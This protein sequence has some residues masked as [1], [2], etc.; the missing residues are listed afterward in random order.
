MQAWF[1]TRPYMIQWERLHR[2]RRRTAP[3]MTPISSDA[4]TDADEAFDYLLVLYASIFQMRDWIAAS[5]PDLKTDVEDLFKDSA[6]L[7]LTRDLANGSKHMTT[8]GYSDDGSA[9]VARAYVGA[10]EIRYAVPRPVGSGGNL[11]ALPFADRCIEELRA[12]LEQ[13]K[14][15]Q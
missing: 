5:R 11:E 13:R 12:Y 1:H 8:T 6:N 15:L 7:T 2:W 10:G 14:L 9:S 3:A 4:V